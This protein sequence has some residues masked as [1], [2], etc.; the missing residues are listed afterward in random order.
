MYTVQVYTGVGDHTLQD[1]G[2]MTGGWRV[3]EVLGKCI[4]MR[5]YSYPVWS[6]NC[7]PAVSGLAAGKTGHQA[8][9]YN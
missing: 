6:N 8:A 5:V 1:T 2:E 4:G 7:C 3:E 9:R